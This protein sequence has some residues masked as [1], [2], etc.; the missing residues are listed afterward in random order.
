MSPWRYRESV[1]PFL[2]FWL[3]NSNC[4]LTMKSAKAG[5]GELQRSDNSASKLSY[6]IYQHLSLHTK[7]QA[8]THSRGLK[9]SCVVGTRYFSSSVW[10]CFGVHTLA[11]A[12]DRSPVLDWEGVCPFPSGAGKF[13]HM[14]S[15]LQFLS[16]GPVCS[17][18]IIVDAALSLLGPC[19]LCSRSIGCNYD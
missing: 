18:I 17:L 10:A 2:S 5:S 6:P 13:D 9:R 8:V 15:Y 19:H 12:P 3:L 1:N 11:F 7:L 16:Q 14:G 4:W